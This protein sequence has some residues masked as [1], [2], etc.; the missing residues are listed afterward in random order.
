M[1]EDGMENKTIYEILMA[2]HTI[3]CKIEGDNPI[4]RINNAEAEINK[5]IYTRKEISLERL[6]D[7]IHRFI[8]SD[9]LVKPV[10]MAYMSFEDRELLAKAIKAELGG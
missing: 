9:A 6:E 8:K 1:R 10:D 7:V 2:L 3:P 4:E 5:I